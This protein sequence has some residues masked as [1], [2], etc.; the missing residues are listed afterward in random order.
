MK[1]QLQEEGLGRVVDVFSVGKGYCEAATSEIDFPGPGSLNG[2]SGSYRHRLK[3]VDFPEGSRRWSLLL[4][5]LIF[6]LPSE[7]AATLAG[8]SGYVLFLAEVPCNI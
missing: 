4:P 7:E 5:V 1:S 6:Q 8:V 3:I 2:H